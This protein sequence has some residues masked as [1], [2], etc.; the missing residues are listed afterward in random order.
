MGGALPVREIKRM[1]GGRT[2]VGELG[3][4]DRGRRK[5]R[6]NVRRRTGGVNGTGE[7]GG[8]TR[9]RG[10]AGVGGRSSYVQAE[11]GTD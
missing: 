2:G 8:Q 6:G 10:E 5:G 3:D 11:R 7:N 4:G 9:G 1:M